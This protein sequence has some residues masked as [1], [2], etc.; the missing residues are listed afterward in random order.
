MPFLGLG[1]L[2]ACT[3]LTAACCSLSAIQGLCR[4]RAIYSR[5]YEDFMANPNKVE[6]RVVWFAA[7]DLNTAV[8]PGHFAV[9]VGGGLLLVGGCT[10][11]AGG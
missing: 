9:L 2:M 5:A 8:N 3:G 10:L 7:R 4:S 11:L 6:N 1:V